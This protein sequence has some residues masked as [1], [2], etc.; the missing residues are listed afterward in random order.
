MLKRKVFSVAW[1]VLMVAVLLS[2]WF[3]AA[4]LS[5]LMDALKCSTSFKT[6]FQLCVSLRTRPFG[7]VWPSLLQMPRLSADDTFFDSSL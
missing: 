6:C 1:L 7:F 5:L 2:H 3:N 4:L